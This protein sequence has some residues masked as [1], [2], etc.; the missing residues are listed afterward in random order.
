MLTDDCIVTEQGKNAWKRFRD[1][2]NEYHCGAKETGNYL[3]S[4]FKTQKSLK[5]LPFQAF[6]SFLIV[7]TEPPY[8]V[9]NY[10]V[11]YYFFMYIYY[12]K[13]QI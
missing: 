10:V 11:P 13:R 7:T 5:L 9:W 12:F 6:L 1:G 2:R 8:I 3:F 4:L